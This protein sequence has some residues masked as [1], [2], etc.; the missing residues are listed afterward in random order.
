MKFYEILNGSEKTVA[1]TKIA[2][3]K[4]DHEKANFLFSYTSNTQKNDGRRKACRHCVL[5]CPN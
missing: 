5:A 3:W 1:I 4:S 2:D